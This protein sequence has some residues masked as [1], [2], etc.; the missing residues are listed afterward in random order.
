MVTAKGF[1]CV[2]STYMYLNHVDGAVGSYTEYWRDI[3]AG[4]APTDMHKMLGGEVSMWTDDYCYINQCGA[5][6][7]PT[8]AAASLYAPDQDSKFAASIAG[9]LFPRT[10]VGAGSLWN[11]KSNLNSTSDEFLNAMRVQNS[12]MTAR[13][14][15]TCP[16]NC[17]CDLLTRCGKPY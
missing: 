1:Q 13:G 14:L 16:T 10:S 3:A 6:P 7:G 12:R 11:Y 4:V 9:V 8:P 5:K 15:D 2:S 17:T